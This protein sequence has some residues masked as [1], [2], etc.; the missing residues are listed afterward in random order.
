MELL[1]RLTAWT[2]R[3]PYLVIAVILLSLVPAIWIA[4]S[5]TLETSFTELL[6]ENYPAVR[7]LK[8]G[9]AK[10]GGSA[11]AVV[12]VGAEDRPTAERYAEALAKKLETLEVVRYVQ[13]KMDVEFIEKH[14]L[15]YLDVAQLKNL[16]AEVEEEIDKRTIE[17][18][19][20]GVDLEEEDTS[21]SSESALDLEGRFRREVEARG[22]P[23]QKYLIGKDG[24]YLYVFL[25][26]R[27]DTG[28]MDFARR[29]QAA[30]EEAAFAVKEAGGF[31]KSL[32]LRF[33]GSL[34]I[35]IEEDQFLQRDLTR[36]SLIGF[37]GVVLLLV[38]YTRRVRTLLLLSMPLI[39]GIS[40]T[41]AFAQLAIGR[42]NIISGF[43]ASILS[44]LG[45]EFGIHLLLRY[46]EQRG[47]GHPVDESNAEAMQTTG[48]SLVGSALTNAGAFF[49]VSFAGFQGFSEFG[50]IAGVGMIVTLIVTLFLFP[51]VNVAFER[52]RPMKVSSIDSAEE[53]A[54]PLHVPAVIRWFVLAAVPIF[55]A[56]SIYQLASGHVRFR[57]NW[58]ELKG[59]SPA[60]D[61][62][63]YMIR[64]L[65]GSF[66]Q[67]LILAG[68]RAQIDQIIESVE[69]VAKKR[70]SEGKPFGVTRTVS[71]NDLIPRDQDERLAVIADLREQLERV[72]LERLAP[73][74]RKRFEDAL[75]LTKID[76]F[77][78]NDVPE[79]LRQ[80]FQTI[81]RIGSLVVLSTDY[82]FYESSEV[83]SWAEQMSEL[84]AELDRRGLEAAP[85]I[86]ENWIA[87]TVFQI[88]IAD[89]PF[90][91]SATLI[92][93][94]LIILLD[95]RN[96]KNAVLVLGSLLI[97]QICI[98]GG[99]GMLGLELNFINSAIVPIIVGVSIDNAVHIYHRYLEGGPH[100]IPQVL[101]YTATATALSSATN[102]FGFGA[103][104][105]AH[106]AGLRSVGTLAILGITLT[107][108]STS[109]FFPLALQAF[110][111]VL[112]PKG[113][114]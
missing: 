104:I 101:R 93:V 102:M 27:G 112:S 1:F 77:D 8:A 92:V 43:L 18:A 32:D 70:E 95:F 42:L 57:T 19:G 53:E 111:S 4:S 84:R 74:D 51:A 60:S 107:F 90:I 100:S 64:S 50:V 33:S 75:A 83:V 15:L 108:I 71:L 99:M 96:L 49:V 109:I 22:L 94:F 31:P 68:D 55:A 98:A 29:A 73:E 85:I 37:T 2:L 39:A 46:L 103:M 23:F 41:F 38:L 44:G 113:G 6:P 81:D 62:D 66:T 69:A 88:I 40:W 24:K 110:G 87:G 9:I 65:G 30:V 11:F 7:D 13:A 14:R 3:R 12:A 72:K 35:R 67:S 76:R 52:I 82:L 21:T 106:H 47:R 5:L 86:S 97:G 91:F 79:S 26:L 63:D 56:F 58:R 45:I 28:N 16:V 54:K 105:V 34:V 59:S 48:R 114:H 80:R 78:L 61:F 17:E 89:G 10:T 25:S 20:L 36:A